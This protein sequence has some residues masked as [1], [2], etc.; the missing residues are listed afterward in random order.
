MWTPR[1]PILS[2][3]A[4][5]ASILTRRCFYC[6]KPGGDEA[7]EY[8]TITLTE[9]IVTS[10][11]VGGSEGDPVIV[12]NFSLNFGKFKYSY[13]PQDE[14]GAKGGGTVDYEGDIAKAVW[15]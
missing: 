6:A 5:R 8:L 1:H 2:G 3:P 13:Q 15:K 4:V 11:S 9:V 10:V 7:L 14:K 12:E